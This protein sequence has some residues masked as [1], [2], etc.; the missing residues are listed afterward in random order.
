MILS[1]L[2]VASVPEEAKGTSLIVTTSF[3][4]YPDPWLFI[5]TLAMTPN[6]LTVTSAVAPLPVP[7]DRF[8]LNQDEDA[9]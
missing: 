4:L 5:A 7:P 1:I 2:T 3:T 6:A 8:T 9:S